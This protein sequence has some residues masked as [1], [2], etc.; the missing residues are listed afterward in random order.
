[1]NATDVAIRYSKNGPNKNRD[2]NNLGHQYRLRIKQRNKY[3]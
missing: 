2:E 1:M 3:Y